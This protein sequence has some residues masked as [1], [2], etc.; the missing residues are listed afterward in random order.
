ARGRPIVNILP[1]DENERITAILPISA[2]EEDKFVVMATAGGIVKKIALTEFS[3]PRSSGI[4]ALNLRD[5][6][7]L[8][9]VDI[10]NGN[11]EIMLF[12]SQ[13]RV[14]RF[15]ESAVRPMGRTATGVR[16]IKL[17]LTNDLSD[18]E[19]AVEIEDVSEDNS[20][21]TLDL[22]I[23]KV[24]SLVVPKNAGAILTA[25]QNGYGKRTALEEYPTKSRNTK[26][27]ISIKVSERNGKVVAATQVE[28]NDQIMLITDAGTLVRTRVNEVSIVGRNTQGVRLIRTAEDEQVVSLE[29]VCDVDD[30]E[31][32]IE[33]DNVE[34]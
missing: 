34:E 23:D 20:E 14:V 32:D 5:E 30:E 18:D 4:I 28:E 16:G 27:V 13:G 6:D 24:V 29:R 11:D 10:T 31:S 17:A 33:I 9:G 22:N 21:E 15:A 19:S 2:Y 7:E 26:G 1:L 3:R 12:S 8:I 25:T